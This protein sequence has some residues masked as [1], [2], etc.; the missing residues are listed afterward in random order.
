[1]TLIVLVIG[2]YLT[3]GSQH[4]NTAKISSNSSLPQ[5][6]KGTPNY[7]TILPAGKN[8]LTLG[9][10]TR[11]SPP[12]KSPVYVYADK[13]DS[14]QIDVS[15]QPLPANLQNNTDFQ[16]AQ[17]AQSFGATDKFTINGTTVYIGTASSNEQ[18]V[19]FYEKDLL[20]LIKSASILTNNQ[21]ATYI[22]SLH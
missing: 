15:E 10:W 21:W 4:K 11:I 20:I 6:S 13:I 1:M 2:S 18:S 17:L 8:I 14:V 5:L 7:P 3:F 12:N 19:I 16:I 22:N 9:G